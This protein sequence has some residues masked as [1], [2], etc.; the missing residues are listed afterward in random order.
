VLLA[1]TY[2]GR[3]ITLKHNNIEV[4]KS[5]YFFEN[6][7]QSIYVIKKRE[8]EKSVG[9]VI[10]R[11]SEVGKNDGGG[12]TDADLEGGGTNNNNDGGGGYSGRDEKIMK[13]KQTSSKSSDVILII[14]Y[15]NDEDRRKIEKLESKKK[16]KSLE[17]EIPIEKIDMSHFIKMITSLTEPLSSSSSKTPVPLPMCICDVSNLNVIQKLNTSSFN[18]IISP[19]VVNMFYNRLKTLHLSW[20]SEK[21]HHLL[22][23]VLSSLNDAVSSFS[24]TSSCSQG[25]SIF[26][27]DAYGRVYVCDLSLFFIS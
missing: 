19:I 10:V 12:G 1:G 3:V 23:S 13:G 14:S 20:S 5:G 22:S 15:G 2:D 25:N 7:I 27:G 24:P 26:F 8:D 11:R 16:P 21:L 6:A 17:D 18:L 4:L 9:G